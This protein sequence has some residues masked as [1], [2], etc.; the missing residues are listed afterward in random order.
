MTPNGETNSWEFLQKFYHSNTARSLSMKGHL[1]AELC[2]A[3]RGASKRGRQKGSR[4]YKRQKKLVF[5]PMTKR[6]EAFGTMR[7][8]FLLCGMGSDARGFLHD[9]GAVVSEALVPFGQARPFQGGC[10]RSG[11]VE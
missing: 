8:D 3:S 6:L 2:L 5:C 4:L 1:T 9:K 11:G 10:D 7:A